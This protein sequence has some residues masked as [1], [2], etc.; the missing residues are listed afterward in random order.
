MIIKEGGLACGQEDA[1]KNQNGGG[2]GGANIMHGR[3]RNGS[4]GRWL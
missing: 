3:T 2:G 4:A 1:F